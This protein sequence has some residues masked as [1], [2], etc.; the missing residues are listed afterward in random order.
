[1]NIENKTR[2]ND[3]L[4]WRIKKN[5][6]LMPHISLEKLYNEAHRT[7]ESFIKILNYEI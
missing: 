1:M 6:D 5:N 4:N 2:R 7:N 3:I